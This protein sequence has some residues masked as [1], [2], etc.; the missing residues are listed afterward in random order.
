MY[1]FLI[2]NDPIDDL[3]N[4]YYTNYNQLKNNELDNCIITNGI[5]RVLCELYKCRDKFF[6]NYSVYKYIHDCKKI[7]DKSQLEVIFVKS[8]YKDNELLTICRLLGLENKLNFLPNTEYN[9]Y[10]DI[11]LGKF[12]KHLCQ[13]VF[14]D[15]K[16]T[17]P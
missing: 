10:I 11:V 3:M 4:Q 1:S 2:N 7:I 6:N 9:E 17:S 14:K 13:T 5:I 8:E 16:N 12:T 15:K